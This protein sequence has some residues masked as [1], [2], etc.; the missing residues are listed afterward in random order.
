MWRLEAENAMNLVDALL[1]IVIRNARDKICGILFPF[2]YSILSVSSEERVSSLSVCDSVCSF[3][4][5]KS[6]IL[7]SN[8]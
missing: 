4:R 7:L 1:S 3:D 6:Q 2:C 5:T 8:T